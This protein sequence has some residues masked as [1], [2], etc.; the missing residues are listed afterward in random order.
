MSLTEEGLLQCQSVRRTAPMPQRNPGI[1][2]RSRQASSVPTQQA[3]PSLLPVPSTALH[4]MCSPLVRQWHFPLRFFARLDSVI[5]LLLLLS[6]F[7]TINCSSPVGFWPTTYY[8]EPLCSCYH[9]ISVCF[10]LLFH[11]LLILYSMLFT[12]VPS[13]GN[14][15]IV[16]FRTYILR[17]CRVPPVV[18]LTKR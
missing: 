7:L 15:Y 16:P 2:S 12:W 10:P 3:T 9:L 1:L 13:I 4:N 11:V 5:D 8:P 14:P 6:C 17:F 18:C